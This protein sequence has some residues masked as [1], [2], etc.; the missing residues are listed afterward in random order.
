MRC[1]NC[2]NEVADGVQYCPVCGNGIMM[3]N[4]NMGY[5]QPMNQGYQQPMNQGYQQP[6]NQGYQP[7]NQGYQQP[8]GFQNVNM[9]DAGVGMKILSFL[10]PIVG[11]IMYFVKKNEA[12]VYAKSCLTWGLIGLGVSFFF[13]V[14][15]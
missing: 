13:G 8:Y 7:M 15:L 3:A 2:G 14:L 4:P 1:Q 12:P 5:Q 10:F 11:I 6:M 9:E